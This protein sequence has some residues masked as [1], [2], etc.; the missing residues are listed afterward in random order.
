MQFS[1]TTIIN[2]SYGILGLLGLVLIVSSFSIKN[3]IVNSVFGIKNMNAIK[4][5]NNNDREYTSFKE[6]F[7]VREGFT[8]NT[9]TVKD[10]D[11]DTCIERKLNSLKTECGNIDDM[12]NIFDNAKKACNLEA[13]KCMMNILSANKN[14]KTI[15]LENILND[16]DNKDCKRCRDYTELSEKL[17]DI[18]DNLN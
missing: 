18:I 10:D 16:R 1:N 13:A 8:F 2:I 3:N 5:I 7:S 15:D 4:G 17:K 9:N 14:S 12:K 6:G 11:L